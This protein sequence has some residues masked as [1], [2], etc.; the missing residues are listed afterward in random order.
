MQNH[1]TGPQNGVRQGAIPTV[2]SIPLDFSKTVAAK[3]FLIKASAT[4]PVRARFGFI[5]GTAF[6]GTTPTV[7][8]GSTSAANEYLSAITPAAANTEFG[9][10]VTKLLTADT[11]VYAKAGGGGG[12]TAGTGFILI[13][14]D[15]IN[16]LEPNVPA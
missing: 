15:E 11:I 4:Q 16:V 9:T 7:S 6:N 1:A 2:H 10:P 13:T 3:K 12:N 5:T 14:L 8:V